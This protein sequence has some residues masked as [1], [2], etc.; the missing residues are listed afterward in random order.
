MK[1]HDFIFR[2]QSGGWLCREG[3]CRVRLFLGKEGVL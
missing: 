3:I 2:F 1:L